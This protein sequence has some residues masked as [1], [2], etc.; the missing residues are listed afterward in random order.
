MVIGKWPVM[1]SSL[2]SQEEKERLLQNLHHKI[3]K[4]GNLIVKSQTDRTQAGNKDKVIEK[5]HALITHALQ[6]KKA[7]IATKPSKVS[8]EKRITVKK[9]RATLKSQRRRVFPHDS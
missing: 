7:R 9:Q 1:E 6:I 3:S 5:M 4:E 8:K 2:F